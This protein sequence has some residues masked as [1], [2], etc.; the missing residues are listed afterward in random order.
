MQFGST[1]HASALDVNCTRHSCTSFPPGCLKLISSFPHHEKSHEANSVVR[2]KDC[3]S[4]YWPADIFHLCTPTALSQWINND[5]AGLPTQRSI[6]WF[7]QP[8]LLFCCLEI[9]YA[10]MNFHF[11]SQNVFSAV[12]CHPLCFRLSPRASTPL[13][14]LLNTASSSWSWVVPT[15]WLCTPFHRIPDVLGLPDLTYRTANGPY[16]CVLHYSHIRSAGYSDCIRQCR[17]AHFPWLPRISQNFVRSSLK[18]AS[19]PLLVST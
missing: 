17:L 4:V 16:H 13:F 1:A 15:T 6:S 12:G 8:L 3:P 11:Y 18:P 5:S 19:T 2:L 9:P 14:C 10:A 7:Y